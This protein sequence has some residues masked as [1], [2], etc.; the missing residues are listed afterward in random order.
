MQ[1]IHASAGSR[2]SFVRLCELRSGNSPTT[3]AVA[4]VTC[5]MSSAVDR[6]DLLGD[7]PDLPGN[8]L[9]VREFGKFLL[10]FAHAAQLARKSV[11]VPFKPAGTACSRCNRPAVESQ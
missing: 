11:H 4:Q 5:S 8:F 1:G 3:P 6:L 7:R 9:T 10:M 2:R